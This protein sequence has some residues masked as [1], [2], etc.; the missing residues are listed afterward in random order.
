MKTVLIVED[1]KMIRQGIRTMVQRS[2][3]PVEIIMECN[4]GEAALEILKEQKIDVMFTDIR[5]PKMDGIQ[6]VNEIQKL[7]NKPLIVA[8]SG[9]DD[10]SYAVEMLRNGVM[11]YILK[12][13]ERQKIT[14]ILIKL[15]KEIESKNHKTMTELR[16]GKKQ[17]KYLLANEE[18]SEEEISLLVEKYEEQFF[19]NGYRLCVAG[20]DFRI[21]EGEEIFF[22]DDIPEMNLCIVEQEILPLLLK[23]ELMQKSAGISNFHRGLRELK[24]AYQEAVRARKI[25]FYEEKSWEEYSLESKKAREEIMQQILKLVEEQAWDKR[26]QLIGTDKT[27]ELDSQWRSLFYEMKKNRLPVEKFEAGIEYFL[28]ELCKIYS[29]VIGEEEKKKIE[30]C[31]TIYQF[32]NISEYQDYFLGVMFDIHSRINDREDSSRNLQKIKMAVQYIEEHYN[33]DLN[34]A[35]VSNYISMNYSLFSYA[36]KQ[37]TGSTFVNFLKD[38]RISEAKRLLQETDERIIDISRQIGYENE[39]HFM[40]IFKGSCGVSPTE[41]RKN[42]RQE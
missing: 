29:S 25:A 22:V 24:I 16:I 15:E 3:V 33:Q 20:K 9:Y 35:V 4:N 38:I 23:N 17:I 41:Y 26:L 10:F 8:I 1:E 5:M 14:Q 28:S 37:Y 7:E 34:M 42:M 18:T 36:F 31:R 30:P 6:L 40:K 27:E 13:V 12:P 11:E 2:G 39:K 19:Q 32:R 21:E